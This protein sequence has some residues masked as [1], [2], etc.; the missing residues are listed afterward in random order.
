MGE[1]ELAA[2][3]GGVEFRVGGVLLLVE[4]GADSEEV[5]WV[6]CHRCCW[7]YGVEDLWVVV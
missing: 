4:N 6:D 7:Y 1:L 5:S 3:E 2:G